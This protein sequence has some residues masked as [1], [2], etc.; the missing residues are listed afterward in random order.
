MKTV[1]IS[2]IH[3]NLVALDAV[4]GSLEMESYDKIVFLGDLAATGPEPHNVIA[5][6]RAKYSVCVMGNTD[7]WLLRPLA[8]ENPEPEVK[9]MEDIDLWCASQL[10][11]SDKDFLRSFEH[12]TR[13]D[14][15][16]GATLLAY[17]GSPKSNRE[18]IPPAG[19]ASDLE[20]LLLGERAAVMAGG[21]SH[22]QM[23]RR[24]QDS[25]LVNPGSVGLPFERD[26]STGKTR[27]PPWCEYAVVRSEG[28]RLDIS[29]RRVPIDPGEVSNSV[30]GSDMPHK[31]EFLETWASLAGKL[32]VRNRLW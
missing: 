27:V 5:K 11:D 18:G 22:V 28:G 16:S 9:V 29:F 14:I 8:R 21:H 24:Y 3:G 30:L 2:D 31:S 19:T 26:P 23:L 15:G 1:L 32:A 7:E 4:L 6:L 25:T 20:A 13:V 17:H 10:T 12:M